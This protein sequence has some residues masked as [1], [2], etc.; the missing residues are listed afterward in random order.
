MQTLLTL[1]FSFL[2]LAYK[3]DMTYFN[4]ALGSCGAY[5][6]DNDHIVAL[7][8]SKMAKPGAC[9]SQINIWNPATGQTHAATVVDKCMGCGPE[10][11]DVSPALFKLV[12]PNGDGRVHGI[13]WGGHKVGGKRRMGRSEVESAQTA[14]ETSVNRK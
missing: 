4:P 9:F 14:N 13:C 3:G 12:A 10:D 7:A 2:T 11:I 8:P 5:S 1:S 6:T